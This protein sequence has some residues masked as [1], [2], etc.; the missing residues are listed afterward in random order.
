MSLNCVF[1]HKPVFGFGGLTVPLKGPA[2]QQC[3]QAFNVLKRTFQKLDITELNDDELR[4]LKDLVLA[5]ENDRR[6]RNEPGG[7]DIELF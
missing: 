4:D 6:R 3:F 2:H 7:D 1:C 5:E